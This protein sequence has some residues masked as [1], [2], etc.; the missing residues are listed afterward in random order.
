MIELQQPPMAISRGEEFWE[1]L[2]SI[3]RT[4]RQTFVKVAGRPIFAFAV[5]N[6]LRKVNDSLC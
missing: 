2:V 5:G 6:Q 4:F 1:R 3:F